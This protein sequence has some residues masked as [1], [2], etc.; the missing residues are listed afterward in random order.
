MKFL[1]YAT[2]IFLNLLNLYK[3]DI[4]VHC[5][6]S[7]IIGDWKFKATKPVKK[8]IDELYRMTCG[9][10]NPSHESSAYKYNMNLKQFVDEFTITLKDDDNVTLTKN[11][12]IK[13]FFYLF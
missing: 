2:V 10:P 8:S 4:P 6:K 1:L 9:N 11:N 3:L 13:V 7:Q 5:L 12:L